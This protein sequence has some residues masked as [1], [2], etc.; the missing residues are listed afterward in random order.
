MASAHRAV[1]TPRLFKMTSSTPETAPR[2]AGPSWLERFH[3]GDTEV[4]Q[5]CYREHFEGV[6]RVVSRLLPAVD[7]ETVIHDLFLRL[8]SSEEMRRSFQGGSLPAWLNTLA[9]NQ[10]L[11]VLRRRQRE[12]EALARFASE[13][14]D[15]GTEPLEPAL[16]AESLLERFRQERLPPKWAPVFEARFIRQLSQREAAQVLNMHRT[17]LAYQE[18]RVRHLLKKFLLSPEV[19]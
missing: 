18:L 16:D 5:E 3:A 19:R 9:R 15:T 4:L 10:A 11:D 17:T 6:L 12:H 1:E 14:E 8:L 2:E 13:Q 7:A